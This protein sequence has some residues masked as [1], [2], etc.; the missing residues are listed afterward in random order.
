MQEKIADKITENVINKL[1]EFLYNA[2]IDIPHALGGNINAYHDMICEA[3]IDH[4]KDTHSQYL[5]EESE[6]E[7]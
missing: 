3:I 5:I 6:E 2:F 4:I 1:E 7:E